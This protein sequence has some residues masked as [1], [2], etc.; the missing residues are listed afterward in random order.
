MYLPVRRSIA[1]VTSVIGGN[2]A[3]RGWRIPTCSRSTGTTLTQARGNGALV[4]GDPTTASS[5]ALGMLSGANGLWR[6]RQID[7][8]GVPSVELEPCSSARLSQVVRE[9]VLS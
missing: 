9:F 7:R 1:A 6:L 5:L 8:S 2:K 4:I 3:A